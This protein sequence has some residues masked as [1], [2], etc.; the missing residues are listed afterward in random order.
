MEIMSSNNNWI[1]GDVIR[2][3]NLGNMID[4]G[5]GDDTVYGNDGDD[6]FLI[7]KGH[8]SLFGGSGNDTINYQVT[9]FTQDFYLKLLN[10]QLL[11]RNRGPSDKVCFNVVSL[12]ATDNISLIKVEWNLQ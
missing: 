5:D 2:G 8:D 11:V 1:K 7:S 9:C 6:I 4:P 3:N 12:T 10:N